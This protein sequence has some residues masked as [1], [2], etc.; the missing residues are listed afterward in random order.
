VRES[1]A[2]LRKGIGASEDCGDAGLGI[3][4]AAAGEAEEAARKEA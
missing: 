1:A 4:D 3:D 2:A